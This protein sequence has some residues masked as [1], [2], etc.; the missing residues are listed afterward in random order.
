MV[1]CE[2]A[3][4]GCD[5]ILQDEFAAYPEQA[6]Y[7]IDSIDEGCGSIGAGRAVCCGP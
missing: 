5:R 7:M 1:A 6:L 3:I 2:Q 4:D